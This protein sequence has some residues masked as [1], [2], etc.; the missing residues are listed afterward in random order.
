[1]TERAVRYKSICAATRALRMHS[2]V[3]VVV[4]ADRRRAR[5]HRLIGRNECASPPPGHRSSR[6]ACAVEFVY[7]SISAT[8]FSTSVRAC[9]ESA[10]VPGAALVR[11]L[12]PLATC[13][14]PTT[15]TYFA[16]DAVINA[17]VRTQ[18]GRGSGAGIRTV[19][20]REPVLATQGGTQGCSETR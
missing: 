15:A 12:E 14:L 7:A 3:R 20:S 10:S 1:M 16:T 11:G 19:D 17:P 6:L 5:P 9:G 18:D 4:S 8:M 13:T 2:A